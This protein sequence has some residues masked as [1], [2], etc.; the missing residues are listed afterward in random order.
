MLIVFVILD[1]DDVLEQHIKLTRKSMEQSQ[2]MTSTLSGSMA[3]KFNN[4]QC[5]YLA[6]KLKVAIESAQ[7]SVLL[8]LLKDVETP[9]TSIDK[10]MVFEIFKLLYA[11]AKE[12]ECFIQACCKD[13]WIQAAVLLSNVE[14]H[15]LSV[16]F[17]LEL[18]K[19]FFTA[20]G[21]F[22]GLYKA[23]AE[24]VQQ[25]AALDTETLVNNLHDLKLFDET[26][27]TS[28]QYQ[29]AVSLLVRLGRARPA[30]DNAN[31]PLPVGGLRIRPVLEK[32]FLIGRRRPPR[33]EGVA[34]QQDS[35]AYYSSSVYYDFRVRYSSFLYKDYTSILRFE[36]LPDE[37]R[38]T[39]PVL[40]KTADFEDDAL[41]YPQ[42][43]FYSYDE[44]INLPSPPARPPAPAPV[45]PPAPAP[46][47]PPAPGSYHEPS[48]SAASSVSAGSSVHESSL[49][50]STGSGSSD[51]LR[52]STIAPGSYYESSCLPATMLEPSESSLSDL[53]FGR[54]IV[55]EILGKGTAGTVHKVMWLGAEFAMKTF[56]GS[57]NPDFNK[58]V[59]I[60]SRLSHPN[61][62]S[63]LCSKSDK[64]RCSIV[65]ELMDED[66]FSLMHS[67]LEG[68]DQDS[69]FTMFG[70]VDIMLQVAEGMRYLHERRIV[71]RDLKSLNI[72]VSRVKALE[73]ETEYVIAKVADFGLSR[74]KESSETYSN[75][76]PNMGTTRWMAPEMMKIRNLVS[77]S[78][79]S[80]AET[81]NNEPNL[82]FPY[83]SDVYSFAMVCYEILTGEVPFSSLRATEN[84]KKK[85][86]EGA[87]PQLPLKCPKELKNLIERCWRPDESERPSFSEICEELRYIKFLL[88]RRASSFSHHL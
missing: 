73:L 8:K 57:N 72:L 39:K 9:S 52:L 62:I 1:T 26:N 81:S 83:K 51:E 25:Q 20:R 49:S 35:G 70:A 46:V 29:L 55:K 67:R 76:T 45:L 28:S 18:C 48:L 84:L 22:E 65:M 88:L 54:L 56:Y 42:G 17:N 14:Q 2:R 60:L 11:L 3:P 37:A 15:V 16:G 5:E 68:G 82:K 10:A 32:A 40:Y 19:L 6:D 27:F 33:L 30:M 34:T 21:E 7:E 66:L 31:F 23:E 75:Q 44:P 61:I 12:V 13:A 86:L 79:E 78:L 38:R 77:E 85:V 36:S 80:Q 64:R 63:L 47:L 24:N 87:R 71:H 50:T 69:P 74:T 58:E 4:R 59:S 41:P 43:T 53:V